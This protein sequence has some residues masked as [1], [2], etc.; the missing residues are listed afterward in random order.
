MSISVF[1]EGPQLS[2]CGT[3]RKTRSMVELG[4]IAVTHL[5][6]LILCY[7]SLKRNAKFLH[8]F[9]T[10]KTYFV[11]LKLILYRKDL[12]VLTLISTQF[13]IANYFK[14][15]SNNETNSI[16]FKAHQSIRQSLRK[17]INSQA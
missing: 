2:V 12:L 5:I 16:I 10:P 4:V 14:E 15:C 3:L 6:I 7:L 13:F 9:L 8:L 1:H 17:R 11:A